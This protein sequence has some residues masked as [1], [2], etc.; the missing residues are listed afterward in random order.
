METLREEALRNIEETFGD[1]LKR[2]PLEGAGSTSEGA[3]APAFPTPT[4]PG[5]RPHRAR[6]G[7]S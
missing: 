3:L 2:I 5:S 6:C 4:S 7:S 1:R